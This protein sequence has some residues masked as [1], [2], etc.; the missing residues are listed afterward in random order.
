MNKQTAW[1]QCI[2]ASITRT[3]EFSS[4][5]LF[6]WKRMKSW[7]FNGLKKSHAFQIAYSIKIFHSNYF[8]SSA[9]T[10]S[11]EKQHQVQRRTEQVVWN[12]YEYFTIEFNAMQMKSKKACTL[13]G[14]CC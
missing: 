9:L 11:I 5:R 7:N 1:V 12:Y 13:Y 4:L 2:E 10:R 3:I 8:E 14:R 6:I